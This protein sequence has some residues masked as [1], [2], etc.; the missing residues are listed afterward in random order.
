VPDKRADTLLQTMRFIEWYTLNRAWDHLSDDELFWEPVAGSWG[1]R[2]RAECQTATPFGD[3][4]WVADFDD[5]LARA[6]DRGEAVEPLTT[7]GWLMWHIGSMPGRLAQ[8]DFLGGSRRARE[9]WTS[10]Y[11]NVPP[12][13]TSAAE[14]VDSMRAGWR[15]LERALQAASDD[16]LERPMRSYNYRDE[17]GPPA[18]GD[19]PGPLTHGTT[20]VAATLNEV[21]HHGTQICMLR[22]LYRATG[23][24]PFA[25]ERAV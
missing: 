11:L 1:I 16:D 25:A 19:E 14:G 10:C 20:I 9:G 13:F 4:D 21:S 6:A 23:D 5:Y 24:R 8:L 7:I 12:V 17:P 18:L 3:G 22:D 15:S 2:R